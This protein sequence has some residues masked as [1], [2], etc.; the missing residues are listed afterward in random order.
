MEMMSLLEETFLKYS[1]HNISLV[2]QEPYTVVIT[3]IVEI[4]GQ[5]EVQQ[6]NTLK[7]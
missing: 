7:I 4:N 2:K 5:A 1:M 3:F 6:L